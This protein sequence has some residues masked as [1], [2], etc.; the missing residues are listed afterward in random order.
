MSLIGYLFAQE[1]KRDKQY[2]AL[3]ECGCEKIFEDKANE[4]NARP[5]LSKAIEMLKEGDTLVIWKWDKVG[6][7]VE[8]ITSFINQLKHKGAQVKSLVDTLDT[9]TPLGRTFFSGME[10]LQVA[11]KQK[12]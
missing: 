12:N 1:G 8:E 3:S 6:E 7:T 2:E 10:A 4:E 11:F 9:T 5:E